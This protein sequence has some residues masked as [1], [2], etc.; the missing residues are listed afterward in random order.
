[1]ASTVQQEFSRKAFL[2]GGGALVI[3][4]GVANAGLTATATAAGT[5]AP[6]LN[7]LDSWLIVHADN[8]VTV[9]GEKLEYCQGT[10]TGLRQ[11]AAEELG[12]G[13]DQVRWVRPQ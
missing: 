13:M 8:T 7:S 5:A 6:A 12:I 10:T 4:F 9:L 2:K 3:G 1:M 11:I